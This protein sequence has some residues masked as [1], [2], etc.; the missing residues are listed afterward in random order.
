M[1][2]RR[3]TEEANNF[4]LKAVVVN[5]TG[6]SSAPVQRR[7]L[8]LPSTLA[9]PPTTQGVAQPVAT[10]GRAPTGLT[11]PPVAPPLLIPPTPTLPLSAAPVVAAVSA[12]GG[13]GGISFAFDRPLNAAPKP[14]RPPARAIDPTSIAAIAT[15]PQAKHALATILA[16]QKAAANGAPPKAAH[17]PAPRPSSGLPLTTAALAVAPHQTPHQTPQAAASGAS[18]LESMGEILRLKSSVE[19]LEGALATTREKLARTET[20]LLK[21]NRTLSS[22]RAMSNGKLLHM[23]GELDKQRQATA[24]ANAAAAA[25]AVVAQQQKLQQPE[26]PEQ[27]PH[28]LHQP[29]TSPTGADAA[30]KLD[31]DAA[32]RDTEAQLELK[33]KIESL[34]TELVQLTLQRDD[35]TAALETARAAAAAATEQAQA[36]EAA[37][38]AQAAQHAASV[39]ALEATH[40]TALAEHAASVEAL[41]ARHA[42]ALTKHVASVEA[43]STDAT[44]ALRLE[45]DA[46]RT[47]LEAAKAAEAAAD[48]RAKAACRAHA[49]LMAWSPPPTDT[50]HTAYTRTRIEHGDFLFPPAPSIEPTEAPVE[51]AVKPPTTTRVVGA[52]EAREAHACATTCGVSSS[53]KLAS[54]IAAQ[55]R[56]AFGAKPLI[57]VHPLNIAAQ[58]PIVPDDATDAT[59]EATGEATGGDPHVNALLNAVSQD[60]VSACVS[61]RRS[62]LSAAGLSTDEIEQEIAAFQLE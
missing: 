41:E 11:A 15:T 39:E 49:D 43:S 2:I 20:S 61:K 3:A 52:D 29:A 21:A 50:A 47:E 5:E 31:F 53:S 60:V 44:E 26:Q 30:K 32:V 46:L 33:D 36:A 28:Q 22:E 18:K 48:A 40:A 56:D 37:Q 24:A 8:A 34:Q 10:Q 57:G 13:G 12:V 51:A 7:R 35:A 16:A 45:R 42:A 55:P 58:F 9:A 1:S 17:H 62:Y 14:S 38:T 54:L 6:L 4:S 59:G 23:K 25:A 27:Q 19:Q